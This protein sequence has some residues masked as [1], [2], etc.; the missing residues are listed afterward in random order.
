[1]SDLTVRPKPR[2]R[3]TRSPATAAS[4]LS[5]AEHPVSREASL[6]Q[7]LHQIKVRDVSPI[8]VTVGLLVGRDL[9]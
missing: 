6:P 5:A 3:N 9:D 1:M 2:L 8:G 7:P 4:K